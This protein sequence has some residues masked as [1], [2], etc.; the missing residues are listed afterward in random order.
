MDLSV[1]IIDHEPLM[2]AQLKKCLSAVAPD[3]TVTA[4]CYEG[5]QAE[6]C[7]AQYKPDLVFLTIEMPRMSGIAI[8]ERIQKKEGIK[9]DIVFVTGER[10]FVSHTLRLKALDYLVK[11]VTEGEVAQAVRKFKALHIK[12]ESSPREDSLRNASADEGPASLPARRFSVDEGDKI[13][14]VACDDIR[15]IY[16]EKRRTFLVT[17]EGKTY[18]THFSLVQFEQR[19][20]A[21]VFFR[22]HRNY[23]V[24]IDEVQQIEPW[25][26]HQYVLILHGQEKE[27]IPVGRS[28]I[29]K[30]RQYIYL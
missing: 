3:M 7:L 10:D 30:L 16:A 5:E 4:I 2:A 14:L 15:L 12:K 19:L 24:N 17:L 20:P 6:P 18:P 29:K 9:P 23:I 26:N 8:A 27:P 1:V 22:C 28:Y 11:P 13:K 21:S 25:F